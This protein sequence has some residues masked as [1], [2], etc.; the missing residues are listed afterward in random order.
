MNINLDIS[1][2]VR[3]YAKN[4]QCS[5]CEDICPTDAIKSEELALSLFQDSCI[6]CGA[7]VGVC[8]TEALNLPSLNISKFF[9]EFL[10]SNEDAISCKTN[11]VCLAGLNVEY[12]IALTAIKEITLDLG[13]CKSCDIASSCLP[14]I[15]KNLTEANM[16]ASAHRYKRS[17]KGI[18]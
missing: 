7:C 6:S 8:P 11:F 17:K 10:K 12:L 9:F 4:S 14:Q 3:Y 2:C 1:N 18:S 16:V 15:E 5:L 13:H